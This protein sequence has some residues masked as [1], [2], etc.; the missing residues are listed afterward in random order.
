MFLYRAGLNPNDDK[1]TRSAKSQDP[2]AK[3]CNP[4]MV[5]DFRLDLSRPRFCIFV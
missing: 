2:K 5:K 1:M 3:K 4:D